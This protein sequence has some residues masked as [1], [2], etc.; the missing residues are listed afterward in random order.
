MHTKY[1]RN[2]PQNSGQRLAAPKSR[3]MS[4]LPKT[5]LLLLLLSNRRIRPRSVLTCTHHQLCSST[6]SGAR[7]EALHLPYVH[8]WKH[9]GTSQERK[10]MPFMYCQRAESSPAAG[11]LECSPPSHLQPGQGRTQAPA[12]AR[13]SGTRQ[14]CARAGRLLRT[15]PERPQ[16]AAAA[17]CCSAGTPAAPGTWE[18]GPPRR[19]ALHAH[20]N[21]IGTHQVC[22]VSD[23]RRRNRHAAEAQWQAMMAASCQGQYGQ[24]CLK[25]RCEQRGQHC[26][27]E[28]QMVCK[29]AVPCSRSAHCRCKRTSAAWHC[30]RSPT[31]RVGRGGL[32]CLQNRQICHIEDYSGTC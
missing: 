26:R 3:R 1:S 17:R 8:K 2:A 28:Q 19:W 24:P 12:A 22:R 16:R 9:V 11:L 10:W 20:F 21:T 13:P 32:A 18:P 29:P 7:H 14:S 15:L 30:V 25:Q 4:P 6:R 23:Q 5:P 31:M 27:H